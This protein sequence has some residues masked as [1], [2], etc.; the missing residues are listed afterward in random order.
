MELHRVRR[1]AQAS[2]PHDLKSS[3][4]THGAGRDRCGARGTGPEEVCQARHFPCDARANG[5]TLPCVTR[6]VTFAPTPDG[7]RRNRPPPLQSRPARP[8]GPLLGPDARLRHQRV[9]RIRHGRPPAPR[10][11]ARSTPPSTVSSDADGSAPSG[12]CPT[13]TAARSSTSSPPPAARDIAPK[14]PSGTGTPSAIAVALKQNLGGDRMSPAPGWRRLFRLSLGN[15]SLERDVDDE[16]A[17]HLA[18]REEKLRGAG[19]SDDAAH[20]RAHERFGD[21]DARARR[22]SH[23]RPAIRTGDCALM[24]WIESVWSD[25]RFALR[26]L[27]RMPRV[28]DGRHVDA[29]ARHRRDVGDVHAR[30]RHLAST[31]A[32]SRPPTGSCE[33][34]SPIRRKDSTRGESVSRT[35]RSIA[36]APRT[37][38]RSPPFA[39]AAS[40]F[41]PIASRSGFQSVLRVTSEFFKVDRRASGDR[42]RV[43]R[44][45]GQA[46]QAQRH[47]FELRRV[48]VALRRQPPSS[49]PP[50]TSTASR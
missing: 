27:R 17:F 20:A 40:R 16:L 15:R 36:I 39:A 41:A 35:S 6:V 22:A 45:R 47:H 31:A 32:L 5:F 1:C 7:R 13:T 43:H 29:R 2:G 25:L 50:W 44:G 26:T 42:P 8:Q 19:L 33:S 28:H 46:G 9:D 11:R 34:S 18:M 4:W 12:A 21:A 48:A 10:G 38:R 14:R 30:Q 23:H 49:A 24:E 37:S 3:V